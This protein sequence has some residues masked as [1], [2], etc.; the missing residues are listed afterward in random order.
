M[1]KSLILWLLVFEFVLA[2]FFFSLVPFDEV[3]AGAFSAFGARFVPA[4]V[5]FSLLGFLKSL[6]VKIFASSKNLRAPFLFDAIAFF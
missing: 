2:T 6:T 3:A 4:T 5:F 1:K